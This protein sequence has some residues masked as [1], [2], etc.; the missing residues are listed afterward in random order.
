MK[1]EDVIAAL[2]S[3]FGEEYREQIE[4]SLDLNRG[5][6]SDYGDAGEFE[7]DFSYNLIENE[8][9]AER[10]AK[11]IVT[12]D[13]EHE[14]EIFNQKWLSGY[15]SMT[16]TDQIVIANEEADNYVSNIEDDEDRLIEEAGLESEKEEIESRIEYLEG[17]IDD[18]ESL[19]G[20]DYDGETDPLT[21][22]TL[23]ELQ[24]ELK[25]KRKR[26]EYLVDEARDKVLEDMYDKIYEDLEDPIEYFVRELGAYT[27]EELM[28]APF[29]T[30]DT[31]EAANDAIRTDGWAHFLSHYDGNYEEIEGGYIIFRED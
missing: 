2:V 19:Y 26:L 27:V 12:Q 31:E 7:A 24:D 13:L 25:D 20:D 29:I 8:E 5:R 3:H 1:R 11:E 21:G 18:M 23:G 10:I 6:Y 28:K 22:L 4:E 30:I 15:L 17:K 9:E 14:P 16:D